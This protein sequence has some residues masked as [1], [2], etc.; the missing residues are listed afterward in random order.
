M[1]CGDTGCGTVRPASQ[2]S[3]SHRG[4]S[5]PL[6]GVW[7]LAELRGSALRNPSLP[8]SHY[9]SF[10]PTIAQLS[11]TLFSIPIGP[12]AMVFMCLMHCD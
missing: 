3:C 6:A 5:G 10:Q 2:R 1:V 12:A 4:A 7:P 11:P 9:A 8:N